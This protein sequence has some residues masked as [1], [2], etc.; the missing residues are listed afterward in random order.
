MNDE[1][2]TKQFFE[3]SGHIEP[4]VVKEILNKRKTF[5][6]RLMEKQE[7]RLKEES[8]NKTK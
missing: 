6:E 2:Q 5:T 7:Q 4:T 8:L 1:F 3:E